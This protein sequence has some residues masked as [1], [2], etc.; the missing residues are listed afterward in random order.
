LFS[1]SS[2]LKT[3]YVPFFFSFFFFSFRFSHPRYDRFSDV[4]SKGVPVP[5][6]PDRGFRDAL[7]FLFIQGL[8]KP[9]FLVRDL[10]LQTQ[11]NGT[12]SCVTGP[13]PDFILLPE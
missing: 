9:A 3:S 10:D 12:I 13:A 6:H 4:A 5:A 1:E 2:T 11:S 8:T 7:W